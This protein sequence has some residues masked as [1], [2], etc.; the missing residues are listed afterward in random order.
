M[1]CSVVWHCLIPACTKRH[2][3]YHLR[4]MYRA[5]GRGCQSAEEGPGG[6]GVVELPLI[7][8][9]GDGLMTLEADGRA[10]STRTLPEPPS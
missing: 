8:R 6:W 10:I 3:T 2:N 1:F 7:K 5:G 9:D 4:L